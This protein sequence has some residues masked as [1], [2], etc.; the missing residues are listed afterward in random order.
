MNNCIVLIFLR[1]S[2]LCKI[3]SNAE[4]HMIN[5]YLENYCKIGSESTFDCILSISMKN[6]IF[7]NFIFSLHFEWICSLWIANPVRLVLVHV[8]TLVRPASVHSW[9]LPLPVWVAAP[10]TSNLPYLTQHW[11]LF[12]P[13]GL[14][15]ISFGPNGLNRDPTNPTTRKSENLEQIEN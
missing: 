1:F 15:R 7:M 6:S 4:Q 12:N 9:G 5:E 2:V 11:I 14:D 8:G 10:L 13:N 3:L